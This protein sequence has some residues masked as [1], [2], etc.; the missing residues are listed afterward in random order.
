[1]PAPSSASNPLIRLLESPLLQRLIIGL[2]LLNAVTLGLETSASLM[3][4]YGPWIKAVD[5]SILVLFTLEVG[6]KLIAYRGRFWREPWNLFDFAIVAVAWLPASGPFTVLR[7]LRLLRLVSLVPKL[8]FIVEALLRAVPGIVSIF[9][10]LLLVF[11][12]FAVMATGLFGDTHPQWFGSLG[13]S[14]YTL[15]QV[16]TLESWSMGIA[17][18]VIESHPYAW[19]FFI[20]FILVSTFTVL[21]LFIAI[22]VDAMQRIGGEQGDK[23]EAVVKAVVHEEQAQ[24]QAEFAALHAETAALQQRLLRLQQMLEAGASRPAGKGA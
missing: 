10:L 9:G 17:R 19:A 3:A 15:F 18:P 23:T 20:V 1:M 6:A 21:N 24:W 16:M 12:V 22:I 7:V 2:I 11:Y 14:L 5:R 13:A 4:A 8:R